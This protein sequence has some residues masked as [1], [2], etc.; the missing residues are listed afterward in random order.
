MKI[1]PP[2]RATLDKWA[3]P[4]DIGLYSVVEIEM[5]LTGLEVLWASK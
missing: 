5:D 1:Q 3:R 2:T 4:Y